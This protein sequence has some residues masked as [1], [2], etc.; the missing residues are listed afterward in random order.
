MIKLYTGGTFDIP[1]IGHAI[2]FEE[3][4]L[5]FPDS[6]LTVA[7]NTDDFIARFKGARPLYSYKER[8]EYLR[9]IPIIDKIV[10]NIGDEDSKI[11]VLQE[12]P[13]VIVVGNDWLEKDYCKQMDFDTKWLSEHR[14]ALCFLP[15]YANISTSQIKEKFSANVST[16]NRQ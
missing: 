4:K 6:Y 2:F 16:K 13:Q 5:Y 8:E 10:P 14:I 12:L 9:E 7:L 15:R 1:H 11:T 3:C